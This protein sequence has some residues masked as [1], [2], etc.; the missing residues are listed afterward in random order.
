MQNTQFINY[1]V[2]PFLYNDVVYDDIQFF[3][4]DVGT[5]FKLGSNSNQDVI[6][7]KCVVGG[8]SNASHSGVGM[9]KLSDSSIAQ[10]ELRND[11]VQLSNVEF[12]GGDFAFYLPNQGNFNYECSMQIDNCS[13]KGYVDVFRSMGNQYK[14]HQLSNCSFKDI[15]N[16]LIDA[17]TVDATNYNFM[18]NGYTLS[19]V[20]LV[21]NHTDQLN[22]STF[23][24]SQS[25]NGSPTI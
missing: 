25:F 5:K 23:Y 21:S 10:L 12:V 13:F 4:N 20:N 19:N 14:W 18:F 1:T 24:G 9:F 15:T 16:T 6:M 17:T 22:G 7:S 11:K 3:E 8:I 2:N